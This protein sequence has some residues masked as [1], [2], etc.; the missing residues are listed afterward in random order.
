MRS[1]ILI[2]CCLNNVL[3]F[4]SSIVFSQHALAHSTSGK[5]LLPSLLL[6]LSRDN[7][8]IFFMELYGNK[9]IAMTLK[10]GLIVLNAT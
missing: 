8:I 3:T 10:F 7:K 6:S 4:P 2:M 1:C 5:K 9:R